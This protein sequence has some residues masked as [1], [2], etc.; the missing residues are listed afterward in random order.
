MRFLLDED[1]NPRVAELAWELGLDVSSVHEIKRRGLTDHDQLQHAAEDGRV[2]VTRN[3]DDY[4]FW[5][6]ELFRSGE[7]H[8]GVLFI[9]RGLPNDHP[10]WIARA[11][12]RWVYGR[13]QLAGEQDFG[14]YHVDF[15]A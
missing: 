11:L 8:A 4:L 2:F 13:Q 7:R 1:V 5:T 15:L 10:D 14:S 6:A 9:P 3:L 12:K